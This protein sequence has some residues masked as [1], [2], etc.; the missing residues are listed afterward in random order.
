[1]GTDKENAMK[2]IVSH[3]GVKREIDGE[4]SLCLAKRDAELMLD[5]LKRF[6][7]GDIAY[8]WLD[9]REPLPAV[10]NQKPIGWREASPGLRVMTAPN[11]MGTDPCCH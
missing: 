9:V 1:M 3:H 2:V 11:H 6:V 10:P 7:G 4:F 5:A 8:G